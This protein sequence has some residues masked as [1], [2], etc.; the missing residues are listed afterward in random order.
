MGSTHRAVGWALVVVIAA[1]LA[2]STGCIA[3]EG[4]CGAPESHWTGP[5]APVTP[6]TQ[7]TAPTVAPLADS[8][9]ELEV[10]AFEASCGTMVQSLYA[11]AAG[12]PSGYGTAASPVDLTTA[13]NRCSGRACRV[14][15][16]AGT[17]VLPAGG[18]ISGCVVLEGGYSA[19]D[20]AWVLGGE[21]TTIHGTIGVGGRAWIRN[22]DI[23]G[24]G[25]GVTT[26]GAAQLVVESATV[27]GDG[28]AIFVDATDEGAQTRLCGV[29]ASGQRGV[30]VGE[31]VSDVRIER[32]DWQGTDVGVY[33]ATGASDVEVRGAT[34]FGENAGVRVETDGQVTLRDNDISSYRSPLSG[35]SEDMTI[36][37]N[38]LHLS[39]R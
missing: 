7:P 28:Y 22:V 19:T 5:P 23:A 20:A 8:C 33:V 32:G 18:Q 16:A 11:S 29:E 39:S 13:L 4:G 34:V 17:Y 35:D 38:D 14:R 37:G 31:G 10:A 24:A 2:T 6:S 1:S 15:V 30:V 12:T 25:H 3:P 21:R 9:G 27:H 26:S 36:E